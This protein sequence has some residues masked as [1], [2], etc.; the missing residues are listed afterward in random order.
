MVL[1]SVASNLV[2]ASFVVK[3]LSWSFYA[4]ML[5]GAFYSF[6]Q[7]LPFTHYFEMDEVGFKYRVF[8]FVKKRKWSEC[9]EVFLSHNPKILKPSQEQIL[10]GKDKVVAINFKKPSVNEKL[11]KNTS[12]FHFALIEDLGFNSYVLIKKIKEYY[13]ESR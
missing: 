3:F 7:A 13:S 1:D 8:P 2:D 12:N 5:F 9:K 11:T 6:F 4:F 10:S